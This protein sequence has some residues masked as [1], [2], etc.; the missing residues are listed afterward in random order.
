[1]HRIPLAR[2]IDLAKQ[3][4]VYELVKPMMEFDPTT[5]GTIDEKRQ[6]LTKEQAQLYD[7]Q[8][9]TNKRK[10]KHVPSVSGTMLAQHQQQA[11]VQ[12][13]QYQ[14]QQQQHYDQNQNHHQPWKSDNEEH[15]YPLQKRH[16]PTS[17][18]EPT[19]VPPNDNPAYA[20]HTTLLMSIF[21]SD[22]SG[23]ITELFKT[24]KDI[25]VNLA[26]DEQGNS[27][28][29]WAAS[30]GRSN[31]AEQLITHGADINRQNYAGET[32]L[33]RSVAAT[34][35]FDRDCFRRLLKLLEGSIPM[36]DHKHRNIIHHTAITAG[37]HGREMAAL[38]YMHHLLNQLDKPL[39][40]GQTK[41]TLLDAQDDQ[42][43]TAINIAARL[44]CSKMTDLLS[45]AGANKST[46]N[47]LGL[48]PNDYIAGDVKVI[49]NPYLLSI[50][51]VF[52]IHSHQIMRPLKM[53]PTQ[54]FSMYHRLLTPHSIQHS[55]RSDLQAQLKGGKKS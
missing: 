40:S 34:N 16:H 5:C 4:Q 7:R 45:E 39:S 19:H 29:H 1:M 49:Y 18:N 47:N 32:A 46:E 28:L 6:V 42:G 50:L 53:T 17:S 48:T 35:N 21:L 33:M 38:Y 31:T 3:Y 51:T 10:R 41:S 43:D 24:S 36:V 15:P 13:R 55:I 25:D 8:A 27:A 30:L 26:L 2:S 52:Q 22:D 54:L 37:I 12:P 23:N 44:D 14:P 11:N 9:Q 20:K